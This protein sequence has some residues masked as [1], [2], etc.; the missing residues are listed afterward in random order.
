[1]KSDLTEI[2]VANTN[3]VKLSGC[4]MIYCDRGVIKVENVLYARRESMQNFKQK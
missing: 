3:I 4:A 1:M 2:V